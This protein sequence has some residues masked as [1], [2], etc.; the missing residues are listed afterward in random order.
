LKS[1]GVTNPAGEALLEFKLPGPLKADDVEIK[2]IA[3]REGFLQEAEE[4]ISLLYPNRVLVS[5]DKPLYQ[6]GQTLRVRVLGL[7]RDRKAWANVEGTLK[8][9]DPEGSYIFR[10][11]FKTSRFG[12]AS[13]DWPISESARLGE[14]F[15]EAWL[16][17]EG[18]RNAPGGQSFKI[19]PYDLPN[20]AVNVK[21]DRGYYL[22]GQNAEVVVSADYIFGQPVKRG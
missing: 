6:P 16:G 1:S 14:Y 4:E 15:I 12:V 17:E 13:V 9:R 2:V 11:E 21:P 18:P 20:F 22:P 7:D 19:S 3:R 10:A 8:I 5:T